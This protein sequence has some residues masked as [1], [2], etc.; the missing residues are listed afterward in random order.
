MKHCP[1]PGEPTLHG[2]LT[3]EQ[4]L[5][6]PLQR[7][8]LVS[9]SVTVSTVRSHTLTL[10]KVQP[11][12]SGFFSSLPVRISDSLCCFSFLS[13][14]TEAGFSDVNLE[15]H[16]YFNKITT[17]D[18]KVSHWTFSHRHTLT[19]TRVQTVTCSRPTLAATMLRPMPLC[20]F[21]VT[22]TTSGSFLIG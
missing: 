14:T 6:S 9:T 3:E 10:P 15:K 11:Q 8:C 13:S 20:F 16:F 4:S 17:T 19:D 22:V 2:G 21:R 12:K 5:F 7:H 18:N 1:H